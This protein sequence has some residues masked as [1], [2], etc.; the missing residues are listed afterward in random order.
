MDRP[1]AGKR[2]GQLGPQGRKPAG[3]N[4]EAFLAREAELERAK[5]YTR[6][7]ELQSFK[8]GWEESQLK[9]GHTFGKSGKEQEYVLYTMDIYP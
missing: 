5:A 3:K 7:N 6:Y 8:A 2:T 4:V 1:A 9:R